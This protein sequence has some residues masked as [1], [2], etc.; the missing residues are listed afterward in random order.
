MLATAHRWDEAETAFLVHCHAL[1]RAAFE[2]AAFRPSFSARSS[3]ARSEG[4]E[5]LQ[6]RPLSL[7]DQDSCAFCLIAWGQRYYG[8]R[9]EGFVSFN[10]GALLRETRSKGGN[11]L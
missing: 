5:A 10:T 9:L 11:V 3:N 4:V 6:P 2:N 8:D 1:S 7:A